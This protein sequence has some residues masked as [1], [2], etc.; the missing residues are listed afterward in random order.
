MKTKKSCFTKKRP[1]RG[2]LVGLALFCCLTA[3]GIY[4]IPGPGGGTRDI[5]RI[6]IIGDSISEGYTPY[7]RDMLENKLAVFHNPGNAE[8]TGTGLRLLE[9]WL[10]TGDWDMIHFN[11]GLWDLCYRHPESTV[12]GNRDKVRGILTTPLDQYEINLKILVARLKKT[13]A[14]LIWAST[15]PVP[16]GEAGRFKGDEIR[17]NAVAAKIM[18]DN[19]IPINDLY[20]H[21]VIRLKEIQLPEGNVHFTPAGYT[22]L[23]EKVARF[24]TKTCAQEPPDIPPH[25]VVPTATQVEYQKMEYIGFI[26]F[27]LNTF[28]DKE[29]GYGDESPGIFNPTAFDADQWAK[30]ARE[31][32]M[33]QLILTV[34]H[35]DGFCLWPSRYTE[36]SVK[37]SPWKNGKGDIVREFVDACRRQGIRVGFYL[38][39]WDRNHAGYG[40]ES[41]LQYYRNQ[42]HELLTEYGEISEIW[43]DG[44]NG[45]DGYYGGARETRRIDRTS[46]YQWKDTWAMIKALQ[47]Q[48]L[49]FSDAG[50][51]IR[52]IGNERGYAGATNW[53]TLNTE[54][55]IVGAA[56]TKYLNMGDPQG[57]NWVIPLCDTSIRLG[58]FYHPEQDDQV[59]S[60]QQLLD[61]YYMSVGRNGTLLLNVPPDRRG[62]FHENDVER[63]QE[64]RSVL[65]ETFQHDLAFGKSVSASN[66][67]QEHSKFA[68]DNTTDGD[69]ESY[70][71]G[72]ENTRQALLEID[73]QEPAACDR[74]LL[75]EPIRFGQRISK[76]EV[77]GRVRGEWTHLAYGTTIG[78][79]R[80]LRIPQV[81]VDRIRINIQDGINTPALSN[82]GLYKASSREKPIQALSPLDKEFYSQ[83][84]NEAALKKYADAK[85]DLEKH[86]QSADALI[87]YGRRTAYLGEYREAIEIY[88]QGIEKFPDDAR[89]LRHRGHRYITVRE[90]D[91]AVQ[92]FEAA[93]ALIQET[94]D[95]IEPDGMPNAMNTP[96]S[97]LHSNIWYHL[98]LA[99]YLKNDLKNALR[100]HREGIKVSHN[101]DKLVSTTHWLYMILRRLGR[102]EDANKVLDPIQKNLQV[103]ENMAYHRL[104]LFYKGELSL[105]DLTDSKFSSMENDAVAYGVGNWHLCNGNREQ[106][107]TVFQKILQKEGWASF[108]YIA[109]ESDFAREFK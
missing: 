103:I 72:E 9:E 98:G 104:C 2:E 75:Q 107:E 68:P 109:A 65:D 16:E 84:P 95:T 60:L 24:L 25:T 58:W 56:D 5:P 88:S 54:N 106:A 96:V 11:W 27:S 42:L 89:F 93:A 62:L 29:W 105:D 82:I 44:A 67:R 26:H 63:L 43:F 64:F 81:E 80:I 83:D 20:A 50:P 102:E 6:L 41:Y 46:Y 78:Y 92:D 38:S 36:H 48:V 99:Y 85:A 14:E 53:S 74:I 70:W 31:S 4:A 90:Y 45:G 100:A 12:Q 34:K 52:W 40:T 76:F 1:P 71:A 77:K 30:V 28:T 69:Q 32:G 35:H 7:V 19:G 39:P 97:S 57:K 61:V 79:K 55:V 101:G 59:K 17:Y 87:W 86:P 49:L 18:R 94:E 10:G 33:K 37:N 108:G 23:A 15:T 73:L 3:A 21:A 91:K 22:Y 51:D 8:H 66:V 47:P 13:G